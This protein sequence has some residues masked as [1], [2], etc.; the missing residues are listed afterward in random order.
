MWYNLPGPVFFLSSTKPPTLILDS[1]KMAYFMFGK[2]KLNFDWLRRVRIVHC[3]IRAPQNREEKNKKNKG[4]W[5]FLVVKLKIF[6]PIY[7]N[8]GDRTITMVP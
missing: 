4:K 6:Y 1:L 3:R 5:G 2:F 8:L 7:L